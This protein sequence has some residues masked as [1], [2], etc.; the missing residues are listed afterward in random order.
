[1][2]PDVRLIDANALH[3]A[4]M[5]DREIAKTVGCSRWLVSRKIRKAG[6]R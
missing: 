1:M 5:I 2:I 6:L 4:G 3:K